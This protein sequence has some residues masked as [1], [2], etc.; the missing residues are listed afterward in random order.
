MMIPLTTILKMMI[1][2][3]VRPRF[4]EQTCVIFKCKM[5]RNPHPNKPDS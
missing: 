3:F 1:K 2:F 4:P 5:K